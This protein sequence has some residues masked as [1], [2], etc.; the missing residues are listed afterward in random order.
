MDVRVK[1][2]VVLLPF[3]VAAY[4]GFS[5][6]QPAVEEAG[7]KDSSI[8]DKTKEKLGLEDKLKSNDTISKR[9]VEL[10]QAI[11]KLRDSVPKSPETDLLTIDLEKMC[12]EAG[13]NMV[14]LIPPKEGSA[15]ARKSDDEK[16]AALKKKQDKLKNVLKGTGGG[17]SSASTAAP[18]NNELESSSKQFIVTGDY[19]G[20]EKLVH[21]METYQ[22][23]LRIDDIS[24]RIPKKDNGKD[25]VKIDD[26]VPGDGDEVGD[27]RNLF[28]TMTITTF[29][30]P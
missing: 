4:V 23:V 21:E 11:E 9:Q 30:L 26:V 29:Y 13:M 24:F 25:K 6:L 12:K 18:A 16:N 15:A 3:I 19:G 28:I 7:S 10:T 8:N 5:L 17:D 2:L 14:A 20:L 22:R 27:P 1:A